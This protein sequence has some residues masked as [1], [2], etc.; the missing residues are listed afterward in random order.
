MRHIPEPTRA[1]IR[2]FNTDQWQTFQETDQNH[3]TSGKDSKHSERAKLTFRR[4]L[5]VQ[6]FIRVMTDI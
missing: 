1:A 3:P 2:K 5:L 6:G 4:R